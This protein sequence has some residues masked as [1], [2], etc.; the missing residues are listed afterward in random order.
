MSRASV[1][2]PMTGNVQSMPLSE[3]MARPVTAVACPPTGFASGVSCARAPR[4]PGG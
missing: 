3:A 4:A 2:A 1:I